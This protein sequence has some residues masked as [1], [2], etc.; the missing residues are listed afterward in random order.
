MVTVIR[1]GTA[2]NIIPARCRVW[3][4]R[5]ILPDEELESVV[6]EL[7]NIICDVAATDFSFDTQ[8]ILLDLP[9]NLASETPFIARCRVAVE[10]IWGKANVTGVAYASHASRLAA[11]GIPAVVLGPGD[12]AAAH[13]TR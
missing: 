1:G 13:N 4:D 11:S 12:V 6:T 5:R 2:V 3:L 9:L 7:N 10:A 8:A